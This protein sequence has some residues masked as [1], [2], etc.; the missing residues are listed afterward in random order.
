M[1]GLMDRIILIISGESEAL[2]MFW[3]S[4]IIIQGYTLYL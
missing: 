3:D 1:K 2:K 4:K